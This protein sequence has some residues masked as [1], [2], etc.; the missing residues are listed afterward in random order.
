MAFHTKRFYK[1]KVIQL[2][3]RVKELEERLC[4]CES[5]TLKRVGTRWAHIAMGELEPIY[6]YKC[7][8]CGKEME[9]II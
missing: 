4:P 3:Y 6:Q 2:E 9:D 8:V 7:K 5:H 1:N